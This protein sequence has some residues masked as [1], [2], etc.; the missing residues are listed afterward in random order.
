MRTATATPAALQAS[1]PTP[2]MKT[3]T[4]SA[5]PTTTKAIV[6]LTKLA[7]HAV[8]AAP[9]ATSPSVPLLLPLSCESFVTIALPEMTQTALMLARH[10]HSPSSRTTEFTS[11]ESKLHIV[12][13]EAKEFLQMLENEGYGTGT[14]DGW[15]LLPLIGPTRDLVH[16]LTDA[17]QAYTRPAKASS[18]TAPS[19]SAPSS[20]SNVRNSLARTHSGVCQGQQKFW[21]ALWAD[22]VDP[23]TNVPRQRLEVFLVRC[24]NAGP[25]QFL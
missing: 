3:L 6:Q 5:T 20:A 7:P 15:R 2:Q 11:D 8:N 16:E 23:E 1:H 22:T 24:S 10:R 4:W 25:S 19:S 12:S 17:Q 13:Y 9:T 21:L 14:D 18:D